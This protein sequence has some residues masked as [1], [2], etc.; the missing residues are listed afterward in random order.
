MAD[1][2]LSTPTNPGTADWTD[3]DTL[4]SNSSPGAPW[5]GQTTIQGLTVDARPAEGETYT[6]AFGSNSVTY[7]FTSTPTTPTD[8]ERDGTNDDIQDA[9]E[10]AIKAN[11]GSVATASNF[12]NPSPLYIYQKNPADTMVQT[13][14][15]GGDLTIYDNTFPGASAGPAAIAPQIV[16]PFHMKYQVSSL[17]I[18]E[19]FVIFPFVFGWEPVDGAYTLLAYRGKGV[20]ADTVEVFGCTADV[21][22]GTIDGIYEIQVT[23]AGAAPFVNGDWLHIFGLMTPV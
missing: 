1:K 16:V 12:G 22:T 17:N 21:F 8:I 10:V 4:V 5:T 20:G 14:G 19:G 9:L 6:L 11:Q 23:N 2:V 15:T 18:S 7:T 13:D 3:F